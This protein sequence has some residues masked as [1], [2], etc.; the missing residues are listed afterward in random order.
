MADIVEIITLILDLIWLAIKV[1]VENIRCIYK[2]FVPNEPKDIRG[3]IVLITGAGHGL[4]REMALRFGKLGAVVVSVDIKREGNEETVKIIKNNGGKAYS[5]GCDVTDRTAV[6]NLEEK[7]KKEV[8]EVSILVNNA[9]I[10]PSQPILLWTEEKVRSTVEINFIGHIWMIQAFLPSMKARNHGHI[11]A[12]SSMTGHVGLRNLVPYCGTKFAIRGV[13]ESLQT[14]LYQESNGNSQIKFTTICPYMLNT[15]LCKKPRIR[16]QDKMKMVE[17]GDAADQIV[18]AVRR[19]VLEIS[20]PGN[21]HYTNRITGAGHGMGREMALRF[22]KLGAV[23]VCVDI[24]AKGNEETVKMIKDKGGKAHIYE[25]DVTDRAAVFN[26]ADKVKKEVGDVSILVNNAGIMPSQPLL[27]WTEKNIRSTIDINLT[28]NLWMIQA[29]LPSMKERNHGHIVAMSSMAGLIGFKNLVPYC[30]TKFAVRGVMEALE[31]ELFDETEGN[32]KIKFTTVCPYMVNTGLCKNP[33]IR[34]QDHMKMVEA[35]DAADQIIDAMRRDIQEISI[36]G[37]MHYM[38]RF[39][40]AFLS[41]S[42]NRI[43]NT[44]VGASVEA[45]E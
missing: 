33:R 7:V 31:N 27:L 22:G 2:V 37:S 19:D 30:G 3:E 20:I 35:G 44:F 6:F 16:F 28:A 36:P 1:Q 24:N 25:C 14:E 32:S 29:F 34:F 12:I 41:R 23:V 21:M 43:M 40:T 18:D 4:G 13:M 8:G 11:V 9:G 42:A 5:Y 38:N 45:H 15:G 10:M 39:L 26:L 17:P